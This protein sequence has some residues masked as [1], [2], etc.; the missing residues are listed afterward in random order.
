MI[1]EERG[2]ITMVDHLLDA[3]GPAAVGPG[4][5]ELP[6]EL[7]DHRVMFEPQGLGCEKWVSDMLASFREWAQYL[8]GVGHRERLCDD[9]ADCGPGD[10]GRTVVRGGT[11]VLLQGSVAAFDEALGDHDEFPAGKVLHQGRLLRHGSP[12]KHL[13]NLS[14]HRAVMPQD[15][16]AQ[17]VQRFCVLGLREEVQTCL[18]LLTLF[19]RVVMRHADQCQGQLSPGAELQPEDEAHVFAA[20]LE[21]A[22]NHVFLVPFKPVA[23]KM[24]ELGEGL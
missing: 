11:H 15:I 7:L 5:R 21:V 10:E 18:H 2:P 3:L 8:V 17:G 12:L 1:Q 13:L 24:C 23:D 22:H 4:R 19:A 9:T 14:P 20:Q 16:V 6:D